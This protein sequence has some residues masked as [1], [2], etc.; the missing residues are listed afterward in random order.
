MAHGENE[1][2]VDVLVI[3]VERDVPRFAARDHQVA[4]PLFRRAADQRVA[5]QNVQCIEDDLD[6]T[7]R[8]A[9][10]FSGEK[11]EQTIQIGPRPL[12]QNYLRHFFARSLG[13]GP[14]AARAE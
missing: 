14:P 7:A 11:F 12:R 13:A 3:V 1:D 8:R 4:Q 5:P 2:R 6:R 10:V 9:R